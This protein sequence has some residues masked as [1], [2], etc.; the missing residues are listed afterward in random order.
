MTISPNN[1]RYYLVGVVSGG[2]NECGAPRSPTLYTVV[3]NFH[4]ITET[5]VR[6]VQMCEF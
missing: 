5:H 1:G 3:S 2:Y 4:H 6:D